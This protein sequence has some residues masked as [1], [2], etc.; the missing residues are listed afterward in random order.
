MKRR[1][2]IGAMGTAVA[3]KRLARP[4][5]AAS[6]KLHIVSLSFASGSFFDCQSYAM[7][8]NLAEPTNRGQSPV[9]NGWFRRVLNALQRDT[10]R[11]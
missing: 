3:A 7:A 8:L 9:V 5:S 11:M 4:L 1:E 10:L 2:F 6:G